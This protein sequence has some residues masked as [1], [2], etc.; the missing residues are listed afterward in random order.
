MDEEYF[1]WI[2]LLSAVIEAR[3]RFTFLELGA[4]YGRWSIRAA[5]AARQFGIPTIR[6]CCV[7]AEPTHFEWLR[8]TLIDN[9]LDPDAHLLRCAAVCSQ[10]GLALFEVSTSGGALRFAPGA[11]YGQRVLEPPDA[12]TKS[13]ARNMIRTAGARVLRIEVAPVTTVAAVTLGELA[14]SMSRID[15]IDLDLQG[16][17]LDVMASAPDVLTEKVRRLHIGTHSKDIERGLR[18]HLGGLGWHCTADYGCST[19]AQTPYG[20]VTFGDGVQSW[21]NPRLKCVELK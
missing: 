15:L 16:S 18:E 14:E 12:P 4:G 21:L 1:E 17:E 2:D 5:A 9:D 10:R 7:E 3:E 20:P 8:Q 13:R 6:L 19:T 11:F